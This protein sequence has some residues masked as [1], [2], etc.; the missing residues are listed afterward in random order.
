VQRICILRSR[1]RGLETESND[2]RTSPHPTGGATSRPLHLRSTFIH[3]ARIASL[4]SPE[5]QADAAPARAN[6]GSP[7]RSSKSVR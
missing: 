1:R 5:S 3:E 7:V 4:C 2:T 6:S